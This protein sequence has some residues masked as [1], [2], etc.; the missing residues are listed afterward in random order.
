[1]ARIHDLHSHR[2]RR[3]SRGAR[4]VFRLYTTGST[5]RSARALCN[6][7]ELCE[8]CFKGRY[9]L[10]V[11]DIYQEPGRAS[12]AQIIAAPTVVKTEPAPARRI[13]G[14]LSDGEKVMAG[15]GLRERSR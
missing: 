11:V 4:Y 14:D 5:I 1:M 2:A 8:R 6:L 9:R 7:M 12:E 10:E 15:L 3:L 13:V